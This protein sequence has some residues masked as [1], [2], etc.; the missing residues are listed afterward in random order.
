MLPTDQQPITTCVSYV[1][2]HAIDYS[3]ANKVDIWH[4]EQ[5]TVDLKLQ[6]RIN[7]KSHSVEKNAKSRKW[8]DICMV[9]L[10]QSSRS[11]LWKRCSWKFPKIDRKTPVLKCLF[12]KVWDLQVY[13]TETPAQMFSREFPKINR[14]TPVLKFIFLKKKKKKS[15]TCSFMK[16]RLQHRCFLE[17]FIIF[18]R[19]PILYLIIVCYAKKMF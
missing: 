2:L 5:K 19:T 3:F 13:E 9:L 6:H 8:N 16:K 15:E 18:F 4:E 10:K 1:F 17:N 12:E 14:K 11:V 7:K